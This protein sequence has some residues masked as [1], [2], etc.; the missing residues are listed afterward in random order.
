MEGAEDNEGAIMPGLNLEEGSV[1]SLYTIPLVSP[2]THVST[3]YRHTIGNSGCVQ[4]VDQRATV[5]STRA[6][7][8]SSA[9]RPVRANTKDS[10]F[11]LSTGN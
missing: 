11:D 8:T 4:R 9:S 2:V 1:G 6:S 7:E 3:R 5:S 10:I